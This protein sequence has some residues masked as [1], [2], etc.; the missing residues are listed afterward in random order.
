MEELAEKWGM[1][2]EE[3]R[4]LGMPRNA[5]DRRDRKWIGLTN[6]FAKPRKA[7]EDD[8]EED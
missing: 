3:G 2:P 5:V 7:V 4:M 8:D 1:T 6:S